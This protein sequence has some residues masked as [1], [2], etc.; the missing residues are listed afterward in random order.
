MANSEENAVAGNVF[1][2]SEK[3]GWVDIPWGRLF[4]PYALAYGLVL[5]FMDG[6]FWD[7]W[8]LLNANSQVVLEIFKEAGLIWNWGGY[9]HVAMMEV[10][11]PLYRVMV[12]VLGYLCGAMLWVI[13]GTFRSLATEERLWIVLLFLVLP[14][15][16][17]KF[18]LINAP[19]VPCLFSFFLAW[20]LLLTRHGWIYRGL[21]LV[22]FLFSFNIN[23]LL[24]FYLLPFVHAAWHYA[25]T[26]WRSLLRWS[27][28]NALFI[29]IPLFFLWFQK[30][31]Y[32]PY[33]MSAGYNHISIGLLERALLALPIIAIVFY[34][35]ARLAGG[36]TAKRW[37]PFIFIGVFATWLAVFPYEAVGK[38]PSFND[39]DSRFQLLMPLGVALLIVG[40]GL[41]LG[42]LRRVCG[43]AMVVSIACS[44]YFMATLAVDWQKQQGVISLLAQSQEVRSARTIVFVDMAREFNAF[45]RNYRFYEYNGWLKQAFGEEIRFAVNDFELEGAKQLP[46]RYRKYVSTRLASGNYIW[47]EPDLQVTIRFSGE[48][49]DFVR[50]N[51]FRIEIRKLPSNGVGY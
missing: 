51:A 38:S 26:D 6:I 16:P 23:S 36:W 31:F 47:S 20:A 17:A 46:E 11:P 25:G 42:N 8:E 24:V 37:I 50:G 4:V 21:S 45:G 3:G 30:T 32:V 13:L 12:L 10:G 2:P 18:A 48:F 40:V 1:A 14:F 35:V 34:G 5:F 9:F 28:R 22:L 19:A 41:L 7:D 44:A 39:W 49:M 33:G 15:N 29:A 43:M 27:A